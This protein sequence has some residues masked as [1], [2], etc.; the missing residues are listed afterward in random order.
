MTGEGVMT[1]NIVVR[2]VARAD[3]DQWLVLWDGYN[4]FYERVGPAAVPIEVTRMTWSR[5]FDHYEPVHCLVA[6]S[7]G[8]IVGIAH[9]IFHRNTTMLGPICYLQDLF[10]SEEARGRGIATALITAVYDRA[11]SAG[12]PRV[13]WQ[14]HETNARARRLYDSV[15]ERSGFIVYRKNLSEA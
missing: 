4:A 7:D 11:R 9:Y 6:E 8:K 14:T 15:A 5:F 1:T 13:Y 3:F 12:S 2:S 10:T